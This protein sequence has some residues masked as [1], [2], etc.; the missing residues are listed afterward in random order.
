[1]NDTPPNIHTHRIAGAVRCTTDWSSTG[2]ITANCELCCGSP[3]VGDRVA[4]VARCTTDWSSTG[5]I[6]ANCDLCC[7]RPAV[8]PGR[9]R[10]QCLQTMASGLMYSAQWGHFLP[11]ARPSR[12]SNHVGPPGSRC[13]GSIMRNSAASN[14]EITHARRN[15][16]TA[17]LPRAFATTAMATA[18]KS[19]TPKISTV[20]PF[21]SSSGH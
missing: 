9:S 20:R 21:P 18:K 11:T 8:G 14:G 12:N 15:Q 7:G 6:T 1:M 2:N 16:P 5:N 10:P 4:G 13:D 19:Q 17:F 3:A